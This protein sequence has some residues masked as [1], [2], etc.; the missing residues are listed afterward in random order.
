MCLSPSSTEVC[1]RTSASWACNPLLEMLRNWNIRR[2]KTS[3]ESEGC[4]NCLSPA[5]KIWSR[6]LHVVWRLQMVFWPLSTLAPSLVYPFPTLP[7]PTMFL[8]WH[9]GLLSFLVCTKTCLA[10][11]RWHVAIPATSC[12]PLPVSYLGHCTFLLCGST[13][14]P[15][16]TPASVCEIPGV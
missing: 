3:R 8:L 1:T 4:W 7:P 6:T 2:V 15:Q 12:A 10:S 14:F 11:G 16:I 9:T 5:F 13:S